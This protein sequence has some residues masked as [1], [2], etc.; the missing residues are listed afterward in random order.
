MVSSPH[1]LKLS[2]ETVIKTMINSSLA[3]LYKYVQTTRPD[4]PSIHGAINYSDMG[5]ANFS[6]FVRSQQVK[7]SEWSMVF[8]GHLTSRK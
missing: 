4:V 1:P 5:L 7:G 2:N 3:S 8:R 6:S